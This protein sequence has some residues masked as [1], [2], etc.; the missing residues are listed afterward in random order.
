MITGDGAGVARVLDGGPLTVTAG[1][2]TGE[3]DRGAR[4]A[5]LASSLFTASWVSSCPELL[6][7]PWPSS[8]TASRLPAVAVAAPSSQA[9]VPKRIR[10]CM[11]QRRTVSDK[12]RLR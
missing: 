10:L 9:A 7:M 12:R 11:L 4:A 8:E 1:V 3:A 2:P 6:V 5:S